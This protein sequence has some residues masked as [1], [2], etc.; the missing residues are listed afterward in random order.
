MAK[1]YAEFT[2]DKG[3][4]VASKGGNEHIRATIILKNRIMGYVLVTV[5]RDDSVGISFTD[6][7]TNT[8]TLLLNNHK[9]Q[10]LT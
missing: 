7:D 10:K 5:H 3:G 9:D 8:R 1:L 2:S 4:R 6:A